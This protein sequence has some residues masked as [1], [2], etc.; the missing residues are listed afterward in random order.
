MS[1]VLL[2]R[3][4]LQLL[5][6]ALAHDH[7]KLEA[8]GRSHSTTQASLRPVLERIGEGHAMLE[9]I[10]KA[11]VD[12]LGAVA[13][14]G[15]SN[16]KLSAE[17]SETEEYA[18][19]VSTAIEQMA[20]AATEIAGNADRAAS[21]ATDSQ[22]Q[23]TL[24]NEGIS[25][26]IGDMEL[27]ESAIQ[28]MSTGVQQF[29]DFAGQINRLNSTVR[30]I[31]QQ[32]DL[33]AL[34]AAIEAARAGEAGRGFAVVA[35]EV[36]GLA[37]KTS[38]A[39]AEIESVTNTMNGLSDSI[40]PA[41][42]KSLERLERSMDAL[43]HVAMALAEGGAVVRDVAEHVTQMSNSAHEQQSA[44][45]EMAERLA[46]IREAV[47]RQRGDL[48][49]MYT[50]VQTSF[51][52][53]G[54]LV[55]PMLDWNENVALRARIAQAR[56]GAWSQ[57]LDEALRHRNGVE[58]CADLGRIRELLD[59]TSHAGGLLDALEQATG[60][61]VAAAREGRWREAREAFEGLS[62]PLRSL[63]NALATSEA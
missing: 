13:E 31:A 11:A 41:V 22:K 18:T 60:A 23:T 59:E 29:V 1:P 54:M 26:L 58:G 6:A 5:Q 39:T 49:A 47:G 35:D 21:R 4:A 28:S 46:A 55:E 25:S 37:K 9:E 33:L 17:L 19:S 63:S 32:T 14:I 12:T 43:D 27:L 44:A 3:S 7:R 61:L 56:L 57:R 2:T 50:Q 45:R 20:A 53:L 52:S 62:T 24:G 8:L 51:D 34:N 40:G 36:K 42:D 48:D 38:S 16:V 10:A 15:S 30:E